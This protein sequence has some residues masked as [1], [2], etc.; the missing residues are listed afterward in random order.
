V[1]DKSSG[2]ARLEFVTAEAGRDC[3]RRQR[4][5]VISIC[6]YLCRAFAAPF[7]PFNVASR[8]KN[9]EGRRTG[10]RGGDDRMEARAIAPA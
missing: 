3:R 6:G 2:E 1:R 7:H 9:T 8:A 4:P 5:I 10:Q